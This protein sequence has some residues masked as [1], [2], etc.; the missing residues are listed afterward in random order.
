MTYTRRYTT[1]PFDIIQYNYKIAI[2]VAP[3]SL[4]HV[5]RFDDEPSNAPD[6]LGIYFLFVDARIIRESSRFT[7]TPTL[8]RHKVLV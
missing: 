7:A 3:T 5:I 6:I 4:S 2:S 8:Y 1:R